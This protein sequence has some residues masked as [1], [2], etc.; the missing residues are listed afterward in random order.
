M[1]EETRKVMERPA[2]S[3]EDKTK[4]LKEIA[5]SAHNL[6]DNAEKGGEEDG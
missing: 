2:M 1:G 5:L 4:L 3:M 6:F